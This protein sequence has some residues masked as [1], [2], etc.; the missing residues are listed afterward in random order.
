MF[1]PKSWLFWVFIFIGGILLG[2]GSYF[3]FF[4]HLQEIPWPSESFQP[5]VPNFHQKYIANQYSHARARTIRVYQPLLSQ[6]PMPASTG[7]INLINPFI[8][9]GGYNGFL[10]KSPSP[11]KRALLEYLGTI[12]TNDN[13]LGLIRINTGES[14]VVTEGEDLVISGIVIGKITPTT[15][16]YSQ[17]GIE[18]VIHLGGTS[19]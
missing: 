6:T 14:F 10:G 8:V 1:Q 5:V 2:I 4:L 12:E 19:N 13:I 11:R 7:N 18:K 17:N 9:P 15:L 3:L 16:T